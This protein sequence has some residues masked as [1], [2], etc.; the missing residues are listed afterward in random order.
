MIDPTITSKDMMALLYAEIERK[1]VAGHHI[2]SMDSL[3]LV[4]L[5]QIMQKIY[6]IDTRPCKNVRDNNE[7]DRSIADISAVVTITN[8]E[9]KKPTYIEPKTGIERPLMPQMARELGL[10]Y[11]SPMFMDAEI[12]CTAKLVD[13]T[14]KTKT[15]VIKAFRFGA[16]P[17]MLGSIMCHTSNQSRNSLFKMGE[18]PNNPGGTFIINGT[19]WV[20]NNLENLTYNA[21]HIHKSTINKEII[22]GNFLSKAGDTFENSYQH[23]LRY[24]TNGLITFD[25]ITNKGENLE[26]PFYLLF[27]AL[28]MTS[29][30]D[31]V[32]NIA[33]GIHNPNPTT[34]EIIK[35]LKQSF[36][37]PVDTIYD[38]IRY[39][40]DSDQ[41]ITFLGTKMITIDEKDEAKRN[42][43]DI[44]KYINIQFLNIIDRNILPH[45]G[46]EPE[47]RIRKLRFLA[48]LI[49]ELILAKLN[50]IETTD[51]DSYKNKRI[52]AA[53][54]CMAKSFKQLYN[55]S[56]NKEI[57]KHLK[58]E[59]KLTSFSDIKLTEV[60]KLSI[61]ADDL[62]NLLSQSI[63]AGNKKMM[64]KRNEVINR[65]SS[66]AISTPKN[67]AYVK[68]VLN[69][70]NAGN[71][72][73]S[74]QTDRADEMR[75]VHKSFIGYV[76]VSMSADTGE[77]VGLTK[78][79]ACAV[80]ICL[81]TSSFNLK[82]IILADKLI[83]QDVLPE[84]ISKWK[85]AKVFVNG[86]WIG[87]CVKPN[88]I[89]Y[90]YRMM[91]RNNEIHRR[92]SIVWDLLV[93]KIMFFTDVGRV[94][95]PLIIIENNF[96]EYVD[97]WRNG[98]RSVVFKSWTSLT[99]D[100]IRRIMSKKI[101]MEY[102]EEQKIIEYISA[103]EQENTYIAANIDVLREHSSDLHYKYTHFDIDQA[104]FSVT[105][106]ASPLANNS[107]A[108]RITYFTNHRKQS[109]GWFSLTYPISTQKN[110][111][112]Q[113]YCE[114]P[115]VSTFADPLL[116]P[117]GQNCIMLI[118]AVEGINLEDGSTMCQ[119]AADCGLYCGTYYTFEKSE[120][121]NDETFE[122]VDKFRTK[123][124]NSEANYEFIEKGAIKIGS[125][126]K[127]NT[128][129][130][131]KTLKIHK[132]TDN[133]THVDKST[134][135]KGV[136]ELRVE[137]VIYGQNEKNVKFIK[138]ILSSTRNMTIGD[139]WSSRTGNKGVISEMTRRIDMPYDASGMRCAGV[140]GPH[141][142]PTR[143]AVNQLLEMG[144]ATRAAR[145]GK[146]IDGTT[147]QYNDTNDM[148]A[149]FKSIGNKYIG[150]QKIMNAKT[151]EYYDSLM[152]M[153]PCN[154]L[155][156]MHFAI[157][158]AYAIRSGPTTALTRQQLQGK[159][160][161]GGSRLGE[162]EVWVYIA[163]GAARAL[164]EKIMTDSDYYEL[165][166]CRGCGKVA[167][168]NQKLNIYRCNTCKDNASIA[169]VNS[170]WCTNIL[171]HEIKG[172]NV[173]MALNLTP[174]TFEKT[175]I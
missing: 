175:N 79:M 50:I 21:F 168:V 161:D 80:S 47:S 84:N 87:C 136:E 151:G 82:R 63:V 58:K 61:K 30:Q 98:D 65:I 41:I 53:G 106:L 148:I 103:E 81:A 153:A 34:N 137:R 24:M 52:S 132:P 20:I 122:N 170:T 155:R 62:E 112:M 162:M 119:T 32:D 68:S 128:V 107:N 60:V 45:V 159:A 101:N 77:S 16:I 6:T 147:F 89:V 7:E 28:G 111:I 163:Q 71:F 158:K 83:L 143:M 126:V 171:V 139:K 12:V 149:F 118:G 121:E 19:T 9:L 11:S 18:D 56:I 33:Y 113:W 129:L 135:Y 90:K 59:F 130:I 160:K 109:A 15:D 4:G 86:D 94:H 164:G 76:D 95:R 46:T 57:I 123:D 43:D 154:Y 166:V 105:T 169:F 5:A 120:L 8:L 114:K 144:L 167:I 13:G 49:N 48:H 108:T 131:S 91:R 23:I 93:R 70:I 42:N 66:Q 69:I 40:V 173:N 100:M 17:C 37:A 67:D 29:D 73:P 150:S 99:K 55:F 26:I 116:Y 174:Y 25:L 75:R 125:L 1:T 64:V 39:S 102:L 96:A 97:N 172:C 165:P 156:L 140:I 44:Q 133:Y 3:Y 38:S 78:Q 142:F 146:F 85:L 36:D 22:R 2:N 134:I 157:D 110:T 92:T 74:K 115:L 141:S 10:T 152:F 104:I 88:E 35:I 124:I 51:R 72:N 54:Q 31:I 14:T 127:R 117:N 145:E 27:R 138:V